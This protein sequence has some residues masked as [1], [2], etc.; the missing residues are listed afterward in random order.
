FEVVA[1][2]THLPL[3]GQDLINGITIEGQPWPPNGDAPAAGLRGVT[4]EY[5]RALGIAFRRGRDFTT[6]DRP[7]TPPVAIVNETL[8]RRFWSGTDPIGKR[9]KFGGPDGDGR[10]RTVIG[11]VG[12][13]THRSLEEAP[14]PEVFV[15]YWQL[16][17]EVL[18]QWG[19]GVT[20]VVRTR[21][22]STNAGSRIRALV[23]D[24]DRDLP[25][26]RL[27]PMS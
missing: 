8:A 14:G 27:Q 13:V 24:V 22:V 3:T 1:T 4:S 10:W 16:E 6:D 25:V 5:F 23:H 20:V 17:P 7:G 15:P 21:D 18:T 26:A 2:T 11:I 19:R 12:D 9:L